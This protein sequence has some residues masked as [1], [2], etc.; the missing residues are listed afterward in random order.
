MYT[1]SFT[2]SVKKRVPYMLPAYHFH[3]NL[4]GVKRG[5]SGRIIRSQMICFLFLSFV[6]AFD[7]VYCIALQ[8][9]TCQIFTYPFNKVIYRCQNFISS[10]SKRFEWHT[11]RATD[12][13]T[14]GHVNRNAELV[15]ILP[16]F[17]HRSEYMQWQ[18]PILRYMK[19]L[20][21]M[22]MSIVEEREKYKWMKSNGMNSQLS[23]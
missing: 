23:H 18:S 20:A 8:F 21:E 6:A 22:V 14:H 12:T 3:I 2:H 11:T 5:K 16:L 10:E 9:V 4:L 7:G 15:C 13:H 1:R 19:C 17:F